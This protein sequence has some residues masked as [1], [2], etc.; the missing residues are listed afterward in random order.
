MRPQAQ[1]VL[2]VVTAIAVAVVALA[3]VGRRVGGLRQTGEEGAV[4]WFYDQSEQRLYQVPRDT[5]PPH[6]GIG[7]PKG[8]GVRAVVVAFRGDQDDPGKRRIAYLETCT[9]ELKGLLERVRQARAA[10]KVIAGGIP[11]RDSDYFQTNSL[12]RSPDEAE[13]HASSSPEGRAIMSA[14]RSWRGPAGTP[15]VVSAP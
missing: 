14:W 4:V 12:V 9:P 5:I 3:I 1:A 6:V 2:K 11:P 15:P 10:G 7:G 8:D 13:W